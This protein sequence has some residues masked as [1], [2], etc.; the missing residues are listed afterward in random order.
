MLS[1]FDSFGCHLLLR[2]YWQVPVLDNRISCA[3]CTLCVLLAFFTLRYVYSAVR[4]TISEPQACC[5]RNRMH[6]RPTP[7]TELL[8]HHFTCI[9]VNM[10]FF[11][12]FMCT[13]WLARHRVMFSHESLLSRL[14]NLI[15]WWPWP[16]CNEH[17]LLLKD[18]N[19]FYKLSASAVTDPTVYVI[20]TL[21]AKLVGIKTSC[22]AN[23]SCTCMYWIDFCELF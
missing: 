5:M 13:A 6:C 23:N 18:F 19:Q 16:L 9:L 22:S 15:N 11:I 2:F 17:Y 14:H 3:S 8:N 10:W 1:I 20:I 12:H 4:V 7:T 21:Y